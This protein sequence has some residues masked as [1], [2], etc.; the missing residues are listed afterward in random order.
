[1]LVFLTDDSIPAGKLRNNYVRLRDEYE[2]KFGSIIEAG[3]AS[4]ES[5]PCDLG[6]VAKAIIGSGIGWRCG[7]DRTAA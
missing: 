5:S 3:V 2:G 6:I 1:M 7:I 4:G